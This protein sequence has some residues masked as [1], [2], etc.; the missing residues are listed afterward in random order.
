MLKNVLKVQLAALL[1]AGA[2]SAQIVNVPQVQ[3][4]GAND[5]FQDVVNGVPQ[6][7]SYYA[8][9]GILSGY[10]SQGAQNDNFL[11]GGDAGQNLWQ[12]G[13]T[14]PSTT[15]TYLYN[16]DAWFGWSG[17][18]TA[19]TVSRD[20]TAAALPTGSTYDFKM[21][22]TASQTGVVQTCQSQIVRS[23]QSTYLAGH[24]VEFDFNVYTGANFSAT[25]INAYITYG[26]GTDDGAQKLAYGLNAGGGG[27]SGWT[28]QTNATAGLLSG[29]TTST[30][31]RVAAV[32][33]LPTT[34]TE[35]AVS[36][37]FTPVGT[38]GT[39][40]ALYLS[41]LELRKADYLANFAN[42]ASAYAVNLTTGNISIAP[43]LATQPGNA[44]FVTAPAQNATI[45]AFSRRQ[46][47]VEAELQYGRFYLIP[48]SATS[49]AQQSTA[50]IATATTTCV[51]QFPLPAP[52]RAAPTLLGTS[53][54]N[55]YTVLGTGTFKVQGGGAAA[56]LATPFAA[57]PTGGATTTAVDVTFTSS[58]LTQY[59]ACQLQSAGSTGAFAFT[60]DL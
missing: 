2:A 33:S 53:A 42:A 13:T 55:G 41:N 51:I 10:Y 1:F 32:A 44:L 20:S 40:D 29:L 52:M 28:G 50:G 4:V 26:T 57:I 46:D 36:V 17:T 59:S 7:P 8:S 60:A 48:E 43:V 45:P 47:T 54:I 18:S 58:G 21:Q 19:F 22:R 34:A 12:R 16:A 31:Y 27:S 5:I 35:V 9:Q 38:A 3:S 39:T 37:C 24:T 15:T 49:G 14:G 25:S 11:I 6:A 23:L 30:S 56:A